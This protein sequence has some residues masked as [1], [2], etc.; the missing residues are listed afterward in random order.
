MEKEIWK[1]IEGYEGRYQISNRGNV[2]SLNY[3]HN[4]KE[5]ILKPI[6]NN[7]HGYAYVG[8]HLEGKTKN[9]YIHRLV[10]IAF[11]PNPDNLPEVNHRDENKENN[12]VEN[13]EWCDRAYNCNYGTHNKRISDTKKGKKLSEETRKKISDSN[14]GRRFT[15][16]TRKK[17]SDSNKNHP[18]TSKAVIAIDKVT[19]EKVVFPS[20]REASRTLGADPSQIVRCCKDITKICKGYYWQYVENNN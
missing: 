5:K 4:G 11:I 8:L 13:L 19:N 2:K 1:D 9:Y 6:I 15:E 18:K 14:K 20:I 7:K 10:A 16:E 3:N 12:T 17:I